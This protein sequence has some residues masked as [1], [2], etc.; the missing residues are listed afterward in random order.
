MQKQRRGNN[1]GNL[2]AQVN[3]LT[4][5]VNNLTTGA[6]RSRSRS[7]RSKSRGQQRQAPVVQA[8]AATSR[9]MSRGRRS[10]SRPGSNS[11][12]LNREGTIRFS[13]REVFYNVSL[14]ASKATGGEWGETLTVNASSGVGFLSKLGALFGRYRWVDIDF[15]YEAM[16]S[17]STDGV[18]AY[19]LDW[20]C[21]AKK[22]GPTAIT[23]AQTTALN[24]SVS[25][26]LWL[27]NQ[28]MPRPPR[29]RLNARV[30]YDMDSAVVEAS[31]L[32]TLWIYIKGTLPS[33]GTKTF[34]AL[35]VTYT[36]EMQGPHM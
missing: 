4:Q 19:G 36:V 34:G 32:A 33:S 5:L 29:D 1:N 35:W 13:N 6:Q 21:T 7:R 14:D 26:P 12:A 16:C 17:S 10:V 23:F 30:W 20:G 24:P 22:A 11:V 8:P 9:T 28:R 18:V 2:Q 27:S 15:E 25:H 31:S 3:R